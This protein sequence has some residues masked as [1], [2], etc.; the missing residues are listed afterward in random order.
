MFDL[1]F[2]LEGKVSSE[3]REGGSLAILTRFSNVFSSLGKQLKAG[4]NVGETNDSFNEQY[5]E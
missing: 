4:K 5:V 2:V 3:G 1:L